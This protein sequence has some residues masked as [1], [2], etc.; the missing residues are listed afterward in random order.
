MDGAF[1]TQRNANS[2]RSQRRGELWKAGHVRALDEGRDFQDVVASALE[3]YLKTPSKP[4]QG[5]KQR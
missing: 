5:G 3:A 4:R 1:H 2:V